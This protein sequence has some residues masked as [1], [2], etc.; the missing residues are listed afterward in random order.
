MAWYQNGTV[1][2][3]N[4]SPTVVGTTTLWVANA[5]VGQSFYGPD[6]REYEITNITDDTHLTIS[7]AYQGTTVASGATYKIIPVQGYLRTTAATLA[8]LVVTASA[9]FNLTPNDKDIIQYNST[10]YTTRSPLQYL[11]DQ[12]NAIT[13]ASIA[14]AAT[15][16]IGTTTTPKVQITG[17]VTITSL[18]TTP[19][20]LRY[21]RFG[22]ILTL[23]QNAT[24]LILPYGL[25]MT[26]NAGD[27]AIFMS[28]A[29]GNWRCISYNYISLT[30]SLSTNAA[31][32]ETLKN[33]NTGTAGRAALA[34]GNSGSNLG[35]LWHNGTGFTTSGMARQDGTALT[36]N[37]AGGL[38][39]YTTAAQPLYLGYNSTQIAVI[40]A[41]GV[42]V[43][44]VPAYLLHI[45]QPRAAN[46]EYLTMT[47]TT[48]QT[49]SDLM[50]ISWRSQSVLDSTQRTF[51]S[52]AGLTTTLG[53]AST[54]GQL[55]FYTM[56]LGSSV[57]AMTLDHLGNCAL[58]GDLSA[59]QARVSSKTALAAASGGIVDFDTGAGPNGWC[60]LL[61][62]MNTSTV[63]ASNRFGKVYAIMARGSVNAF[64]QLATDTQGG[65][66][67]FSIGIGPSAGIIRVTN[68][69]T[70]QSSVDM[71]YFWNLSF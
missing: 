16:N 70:V 28:D 15:T 58:T 24:S 27:T 45:A 63:N 51:A 26:T 2:V 52:I 41:V 62:V 31:V 30:A 38:S 59:R 21:V 11:L 43:G 18:G 14:S 65:G 8:A 54:Y 29:S 50:R 19:N 57:L 64:T 33:V 53:G 23:T 67:P 44:I 71:S 17:V 55:K 37:G 13:E 34:L 1:G 60:G 3:T 48:N 47:M 4:G 32:T 61:I 42:G 35:Q 9:F 36:G 56:N 69:D 66:C 6:F 20:C 40:N 12:T 68:N 22:G 5:D 46:I 49:D 10:A 25:D 39:I 7:P